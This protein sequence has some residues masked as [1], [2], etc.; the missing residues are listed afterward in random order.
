[1]HTHTKHKAHRPLSLL[2]FLPEPGT[3]LG[4]ATSQCLRPTNAALR[5]GTPHKFGSTQA[6][7]CRLLLLFVIS[8]RVYSKGRLGVNHLHSILR[9][10]RT[11]LGAG[12]LLSCAR[13]WVACLPHKARARTASRTYP[14]G[15]TWLVVMERCPCAGTTEAQ[16]AQRGQQTRVTGEETG[17][18]GARAQTIAVQLSKLLLQCLVRPHETSPDVCAELFST[19]STM[20]MQATYSAKDSYWSAHYSI[21]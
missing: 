10:N 17:T 3:W 11:L 21:K 15:H 1:M 16:A 18:T 9:P 13:I 6:R 2:A 7:Q 5:A 12:S 20:H 4:R 8:R 19:R 14:T